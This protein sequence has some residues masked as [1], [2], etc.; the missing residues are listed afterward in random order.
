MQARRWIGAEEACRAKRSLWML[1]GLSAKADE[2]STYL[3]D[4]EVSQARE[5]DD[6]PPIIDGPF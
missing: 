6:R 4:S 2:Y 5:L 3:V 1:D